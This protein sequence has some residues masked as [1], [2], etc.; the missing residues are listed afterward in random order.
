[1]ADIGIFG[2]T[3]NPIHVG[4]LILAQTVLCEKGLEKVLFVPAREPP[5]KSCDELAA[6]EH[7]LRMVEMSVAGNERF[8]VSS[9][10]IARE[11]PSYTLVTVR[12]LREEFGESS[13][14]FLIL[15]ADSVREMPQWWHAG[16][17]V[18][19]VGLMALRRPG[20]SLAEMPE[21]E[22]KFGAEMVER[23]KESIVD[24]PLLEISSTDIRNRIREGKPI[25]YLVPEP[26]RR[27]ILARNLY[28]AS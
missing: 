17:L 3:F 15:G 8:A 25:R 5:H 26:V 16:E 14:M 7:R 18:R 13:R 9:V 21:L 11:G 20:Y 10:E 6:A 24:A 4:H 27:Y 23:I 28:G 2:G 22:Q 12:Q 19:E 1:M